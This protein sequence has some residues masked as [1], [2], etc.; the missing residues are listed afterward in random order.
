[1]LSPLLKEI[2][3]EVKFECRFS[4]LFVPRS[5]ER[6]DLEEK[7]LVAL[8]HHCRENRNRHPLKCQCDPDQF[9]ADDRIKGRTRALEFDFYLPKFKTAIEFDEHQHF[10]DERRT[11]LQVYANLSLAFDTVLWTSYCS[12]RENDPDG[13]CRDWERAFRDSV[14]DL[15]ALDHGVRLVRLYYKDFSQKT[16]CGAMKNRLRSAIITGDL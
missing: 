10:T 8:R 3:P 11:S 1:M 7:V 4:W 13:P 14:R 12:L 2:D 15:R 5:D 16:G 9:L 6:S